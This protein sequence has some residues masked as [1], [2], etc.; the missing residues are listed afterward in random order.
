MS[1]AQAAKVQDHEARI[2]QLEELLKST[3]LQKEIEELKC[4]VDALESR[5][6]PGRP[7]KEENERRAATQRD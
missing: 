4:R 1:I 5:P 6:R 3:A 2:R 7:S